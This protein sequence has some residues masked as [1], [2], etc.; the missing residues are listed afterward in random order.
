MNRQARQT[1]SNW[2][3]ELASAYQTL[4]PRAFT[5]IS[6]R[7]VG[8]SAVKVGSLMTCGAPSA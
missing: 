3:S 7:S 2:P 6:L 4:S 5:G 1:S 8:L